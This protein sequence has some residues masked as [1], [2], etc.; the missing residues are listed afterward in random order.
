[1]KTFFLIKDNVLDKKLSQHINSQTFAN[2]KCINNK[3][4]DL[5][6]FYAANFTKNDTQKAEKMLENQNYEMRR[7]DAILISFFCGTI[8]IIVFMFVVL[9]SL[10]DTALEK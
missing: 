1:M 6:K 5:T 4:A 3:I 7:K 2:R 8:T 9:L 10:P